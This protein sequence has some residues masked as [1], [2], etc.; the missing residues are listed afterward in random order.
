MRV[1]VQAD[2]FAPDGP[3]EEWPGAVGKHGWIVLTKDERIRYRPNERRTFL[4]SGVRAFILTS[5]NLT[6]EEM[7]KVFVKALGKMKKLVD[8]QRGSFI[9]TV[10]RTAIRIVRE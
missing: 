4:R 2:H 3:D 10:S 9:A 8:K 6:G 5:R 7:G 1:E